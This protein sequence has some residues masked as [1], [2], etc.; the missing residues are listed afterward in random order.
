MEGL[1]QHDTKD[2]A[3]Y[4]EVFTPKNKAE[5]LRS[6]ISQKDGINYYKLETLAGNWE[7]YSNSR[8]PASTRYELRLNNGHM[9]Y[10]P[11]II[12]ASRTITNVT[13]N[14]LFR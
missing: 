11:S 7:I 5:L 10:F 8:A 6:R 3:E 4:I 1:G 2:K 13:Y 9:G 14:E 12:Q